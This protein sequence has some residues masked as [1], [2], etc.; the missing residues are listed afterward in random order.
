MCPQGLPGNQKH[1]LDDCSYMREQRERVLGAL[2]RFREKFDFFPPG[3]LH[4]LCLA[5][6]CKN[7]YGFP[8]RAYPELVQILSDYIEACHIAFTNYF[9]TY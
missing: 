1:Y 2:T 8:K 3:S 7:Y 9:H 4:K 5:I 6:R